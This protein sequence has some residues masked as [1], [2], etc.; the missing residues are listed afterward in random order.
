MEEAFAVVVADEVADAR[1]AVRVL[2][3]GD[4]ALG[5]V[6]DHVDHVL[7][8]L[9]AQ[10]VDVDHGGLRV[11]A[12][13]ELGDDLAVDLDAAFGDHFLADAP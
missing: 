13:A 11:D 12:D 3:G 4:N 7:V 8:Q 5:L 10:A 2:H 9:D 6:E 1:A